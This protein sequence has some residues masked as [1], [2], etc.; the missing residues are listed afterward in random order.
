[1]GEPL[2]QAAG[3]IEPRPTPISIPALT[4]GVIEELLVVEGESVRRGQR[5]ARLID[6]DARLAVEQAKAALALRAG[7]LQRAEAEHEAAKIRYENPVHLRAELAEAQSQWAQTNTALQKLPFLVKAA[8]A[9]VK[10]TADNLAGKQAASEAIPGRILQ[11]AQSDYAEAEATLE[12]LR[13]RRPN[14]EREIEALQAKVDA[15]K[16]RLE[17]LVEERRQLK[18]AAAK[19]ASAAAV[20]EQ[21]RLKLQQANLDFERTVITAPVD[22]RILSLVASP[23]NRVMG[24]EHTAG[25]SSSTVVRMYDPARLQVRADVRL[26]DVQ[27]VRPD[28]PV[29]IET[30]SSDQPIRG[31][32]LRS[33]STANIQKNTLEVKVALIEPPPTVA[34]E[35]LVTATFLTPEES[36]SATND[37]MS[38]VFVPE[39]VVESL[40]DEAFVWIVDADNRAQ[41]RAV[42]LGT[43]R[44]EGQWVEVTAGLNITDKVIVSG[45]ADL[46]PGDRVIVRGEDERFGES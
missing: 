24:L 7:E 14:L 28:G 16:T 18:E 8:K 25:Q 10:Y 40:D 6:T 11:Q 27:K 44:H 41:R 45:R 17:L 23:G 32:V 31:R 34:P 42:N 4:A 39:A 38:R 29:T 20:H 9:K 19:V 26:E 2:F 22:G 33:T 46:S 30:P 13:R 3:W 37:A 1:V 36:A 12:E 15:L 21:A 35:M 5:I 43:G